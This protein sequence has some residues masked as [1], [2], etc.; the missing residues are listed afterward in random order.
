MYVRVNERFG[1]SSE[2]PSGS[3][4][5]APAIAIEA[6]AAATVI[7]IIEAIVFVL[8]AAAAAYV[9]IKAYEAAQARGF[10]VEVA[11]RVLTAGLRPMINMGKRMAELARRFLQQAARWAQNR[12]DCQRLL[13][14]A[15]R[16][17]GDLERTLGEIEAELAANPPRAHEL[18]RLLR[19]ITRR[20][21]KA[22]NLWEQFKALCGPALI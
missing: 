15:M 10:G 16:A 22:K 13:F 19:E 17:V 6:G 7:A 4:G 18:R 14:E 5:L 1:G 2:K 9:L 8:S 21:L 3:V 12:P 20:A 11:K